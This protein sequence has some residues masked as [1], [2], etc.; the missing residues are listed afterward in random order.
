MMG[1]M[2][3]LTISLPAPLDAYVRAQLGAGGYANASAYFADLIQHEQALTQL[4]DMLDA[5]E[6]SGVNA[7]SKDALMEQARQQA[8]EQGLLS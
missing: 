4:R 1:H 3:E 6:A 8:R 7:L 5:A 2:S